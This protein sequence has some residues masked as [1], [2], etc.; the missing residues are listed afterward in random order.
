MPQDAT[1]GYF[2]DDGCCL[3]TSA[4][5]E[6]GG[7][8]GWLGRDRAAPSGW[9]GVLGRDRAAPSGE[10]GGLRSALRAPAVLDHRAGAAGAARRIGHAER[11][12][13]MEMGI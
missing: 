10:L 3:I 9:K 1:Q 6:L 4:P 2:V 13:G 5:T 11:R 7:W 8:K 12:N